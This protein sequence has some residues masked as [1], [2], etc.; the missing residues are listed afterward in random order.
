MTGASLN[1]PEPTAPS[2]SSANPISV[3]GIGQMTS[4]SLQ[5]P[6]KRLSRLDLIILSLVPLALAAAVFSK[7]CFPVESS[8][9]VWWHLKTGKFLLEYW[10]QEGFG[11][12]EHDV[13]SMSGENLHWANHEWL[14]DALMYL[15]YDH[16]GLMGLIVVKSLIITATYLLLYWLLFRVIQPPSAH[17]ERS[18]SAG[19]RSALAGVGTILAFMA[20][21]YTMY[22]R[23]PVLTYLCLVIQLHLMLNLRCGAQ[24]MWRRWS[25]WVQPAL[26][27]LWVNLHGGAILGI[28]LPGL[29]AVG[30]ALDGI[31]DRL[32]GKKPLPFGEFLGWSALAALML[33]AS[34]C[35]PFGCD[36]LLL[37][38]KIMSNRRLIQ[39]IGE[40]QSP[41][42][43]FTRDY[44]VLILL[45]VLS[46]VL[47]KR[48]RFITVV[49]VIFFLN[50]SLNHVRH[51]PIFA[52]VATP[53]LIEQLG[54]WLVSEARRIQVGAKVILVIA[55]CLLSARALKEGYQIELVRFFKYEGFI[56]AAYPAQAVNYIE[57]YKPD[58]PMFNPINF[59][60]YLIWRLAPEH[61]KV[62]TDSR[63]DIHGSTAALEVLGVE[64]VDRRPAPEG[65]WNR[66]LDEEVP[67]EFRET[68]FWRFVLDKHQI[69]FLITASDSR[70]A[71]Y[72]EAESRGWVEVFRERPKFL[73]GRFYVGYSVFVRDSPKNAA[74]IQGARR[75]QRAP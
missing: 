5:Q 22:L 70:L 67:A 29:Y 46:A 71:L 11:F 38:A 69:N 30:V 68:P 53:V 37:T 2:A 13:F 60:G 7:V 16:L 55:F 36:I 62:F 57:Y 56:E 72:L 61:Y 64:D 51:L 9:D 21:Q 10:N 14:A 31:W 41:N 63:F 23:P 52:I 12:P 66:G 32:H 47:G 75:Q 48:L 54:G 50:Q 43:H 8:N 34:L 26:M 17:E 6:Q 24:S 58:G 45:L 59:A 74:L 1:Q 3:N 18:I 65:A 40:L 44:E 42:F 27:V 19:T 25:F 35:N 33:L 15:G 4:D 20:S 73:D 49:P 39:L 28:V